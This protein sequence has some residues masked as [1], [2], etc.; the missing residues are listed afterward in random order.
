MVYVKPEILSILESRDTFISA[1]TYGNQRQKYI[2][3]P[4][5]NSNGKI[6]KRKKDIVVYVPLING[7][8]GMFHGKKLILL[9]E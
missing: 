1:S 2:P 4:I 7:E 8:V 6:A 3:I 9:G 5:I